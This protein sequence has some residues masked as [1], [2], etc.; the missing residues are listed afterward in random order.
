MAKANTT[1]NV[2]PHGPLE[3]LSE[4]LWRVEGSLD[5]MPLKRVMTIARRA[6]GGLV[7]HNGI[8]VDD[9][10]T[11]AIEAL[12]APAFLVVPNAYHRLD[13]PAFKAKWPAMKVVAPRGSK[14]KVEEVVP[15][16]LAYDEVP[17]DDAVRFE[18]VAGVAE[19]EGAMIVTSSDGVTVVLNDLVFNMPHLPGAQ[20]FV[21]KHVTQSSGGPKL[22]RLVRW[23]VIKDKAAVR[24]ELERLAA[25]PGLVRVVV[26]HHE[27]ITDRPAD[28]LRAVAA[29][30]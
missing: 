29:T 5:N 23:F 18:H 15:V 9:A 10:T 12:G 17:T 19:G 30:L 3:A 2:Q 22:S 28:A 6:D 16:D 24:A 1:W 20:G 26:S 11:K 21:L 25:L 8:A 4:N 14:K 7:I 27:T 13:A